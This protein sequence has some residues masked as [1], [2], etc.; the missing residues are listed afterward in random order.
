MSSPLANRTV[1]YDYL[2]NRV[3][4]E[5]RPGFL[6]FSVH[7]STTSLSRRHLFHRVEIARFV[8]LYMKTSK[9]ERKKLVQDRIDLVSRVRSVSRHPFIL[10]SSLIG[11]T[12]SEQQVIQWK[13][14]QHERDKETTEQR[15][16]E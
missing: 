13:D 7:L 6:I 9:E 12:M 10:S 15:L 5:L 16:K 1:S 11:D 14:W 4:T 3:P 8:A 2:I